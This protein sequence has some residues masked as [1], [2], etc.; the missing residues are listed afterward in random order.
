LGVQGVELMVPPRPRTPLGTV[1][2]PSWNRDDRSATERAPDSTKS[3]D[4]LRPRA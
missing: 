4:Q 2:A 3:A 1:V